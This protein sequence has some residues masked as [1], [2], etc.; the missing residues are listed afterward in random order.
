MRR[1]ADRPDVRGQVG[2]EAMTLKRQAGFFFSFFVLC[3][4]IVC[5]TLLVGVAFQFMLN[6]GLTEPLG[7]RPF[8]FVSSFCLLGLLALLGALWR[9]RP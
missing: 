8:G 4:T 6:K 1:V 9:G 3:A 2:A 5:V 7:L